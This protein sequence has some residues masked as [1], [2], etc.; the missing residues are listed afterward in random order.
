M[1]CIN[2]RNMQSDCNVKIKMWYSCGQKRKKRKTPKTQCLRGFLACLT[3]FER[4]TCRVG[5][6]DQY[7]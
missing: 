7:V 5:V 3:R 1:K 4:A 6:A 2:N